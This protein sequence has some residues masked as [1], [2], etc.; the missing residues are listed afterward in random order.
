[1]KKNEK[2]KV[3]WLQAITCNGNTHSFLSANDNRMRLFLD[4]FDLIYH[5]SLTVGITIKEIIKKR[6]ILIFY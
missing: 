3:L 5:P 2:P 1:M 6:L 4:S